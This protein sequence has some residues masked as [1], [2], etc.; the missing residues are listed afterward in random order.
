MSN[1][2][3]AIT[4]RSK[5]QQ[6]TPGNQT[7]AAYLILESTYQLKLIRKRPHSAY[8]LSRFDSATA[9]MDVGIVYVGAGA[10]NEQTILPK[11]A[12]FICIPH[13]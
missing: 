12:G 5:T 1:F 3:H 6:T 11:A 2:L 8:G 7:A 9:L 10:G 13:C 4:R